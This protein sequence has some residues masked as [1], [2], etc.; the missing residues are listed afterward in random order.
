MRHLDIFSGIGGFALGL[1]M[2]GFPPPVAFCESDDY[3]RRVLAKHWPN[4][5]CHD[6][7]RTLTAAHVGPTDLISGGFPCQPFSVAGQRRGAEDDRHLWPEML[8][9]VDELRP[10]WVLGENVA[11]L[12]SMGLDQ[13][14]SDLEASGYATRTFAIPA[15]AVDAPHRRERLWIVAN[16]SERR[17]GGKDGREIQQPGRT[18][19]IGGSEAVANATQ[20]QRHGSKHYLGSDGKGRK[21]IPEPGNRSG[22][23]DE[24]WGSR[25]LPEPDVGRVAHG[26][27][28]RVDRLRALGNSVVPQVVAEIG[29]V[30]L[31]AEAT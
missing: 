3:C 14:L 5:P 21:Q 22:E 19:I 30:I 27:S 15:A 23:G 12:I 16:T 1:E 9:L 28:K 29:R 6:D 10:T 17:C 24:T 18:K 20:L 11:G 25:W 7:V 31:T 13:V 2:A 26:V 4:V 8:R